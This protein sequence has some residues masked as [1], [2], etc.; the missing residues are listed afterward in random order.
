MRTKTPTQRRWRGTGRSRL[1]LILAALA[2][3]VLLAA[4]CGSSGSGTGTRILFQSGDGL[5]IHGRVFGNGAPG[6]VLAHMLNGDQDDWEPFAETLAARG[7]IALT[8]DFR[9]HGRSGGD[10]EVGIAD[11]DLSA[12]LRFM[13][14]SLERQNVFLIG[15]SMGGTAAL[16]VASR[17]KLLGVVSL[18]APA[19]IRGLSAIPDV[20]GIT[21]PKLFIVAAA[22]GTAA[23]DAE[24]FFD[25]AAEPK[26]L[27]AVGGNRHGTNLLK[28]GEADRVRNL[29]LD[30][31]EQ[32]RTGS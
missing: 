28:G 14:A 25:L 15:A 22:D 9:G 24:R 8:F 3:I 7:Y 20:P 11:A 23:G 2:A 31:L 5:V 12:A 16:K 29:I 13:R 21:S 6:V 17:E 1:P 10:K 18:S 27:E 32:H 4:A 30:F 19:S 26:Q